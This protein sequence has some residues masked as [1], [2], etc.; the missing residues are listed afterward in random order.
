MVNVIAQLFRRVEIFGCVEI[1]KLR[2]F[3]DQNTL[4]RTWKMEI[5]FNYWRI[6]KMKR[7]T[8]RNNLAKVKRMSSSVNRNSNNL[9]KRKSSS[10]EITNNLLHIDGMIV[11]SSSVNKILAKRL[12]STK[13]FSNKI[14]FLQSAIFNFR[15]KVKRIIIK[16][17]NKNS[18]VQTN[19]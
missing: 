4:N 10:S 14:K 13:S 1:I 8:K 18:K 17:E 9:K 16:E 19:W 7:K 3:K 6:I 5:T 15:N 12:R 2:K 11:Q